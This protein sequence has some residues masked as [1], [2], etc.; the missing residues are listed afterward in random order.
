MLGRINPL[1]EKVFKNCGIG[2]KFLKESVFNNETNRFLDST[3]T[4]ELEEIVFVQSGL[5]EDRKTTDNFI[6]ESVCNVFKMNFPK[7]EAK[8]LLPCDLIINESGQIFDIDYIY[9]TNEFCEVGMTNE[10]GEELVEVFVPTTVMGFIDN[11]EASSYSEYGDKIEIHEDTD[12]KVK[13]NKIM[14]GDVKKYKVY[15]K[16]DKGNVVKVNFGDPNMEIKRDN[17]ARRKNFRARHN[18][19]NPGPR[20]KA[21]YWACKTWSSKPVSA[22]LKENADS[23]C[24]K[25]WEKTVKELSEKVTQNFDSKKYDNNLFGLVVRRNLL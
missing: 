14:R 1:L 15:V 18:C 3:K 22:M 25:K 20:W 21:K 16:N 19:D 7:I 11:I 23:Q 6:V 5:C 2:K 4:N 8:K 13:L 9:E 10:N 12:K 24:P 17:P